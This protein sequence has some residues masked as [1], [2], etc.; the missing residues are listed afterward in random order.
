MNIEF[1]W[2]VF[3]KYPNIKFHENLSSGSRVVPW[4]RRNRQTNMK[5][6][7]S[8]R[9]FA[10]PRKKTYELTKYLSALSR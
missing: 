1:P 9:N 2:K 5:L 4:G 10:N 8:L 3:E 6:T 7:V